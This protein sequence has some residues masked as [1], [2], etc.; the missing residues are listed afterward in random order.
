MDYLFRDF[1]LLWHH[2]DD[3]FSGGAEVGEKCRNVCE[4]LVGRHRR[5]EQQQQL[6]LHVLPDGA[7]M[8]P[9]K[10]QERHNVTIM[11]MTT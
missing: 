1:D 4:K 8:R 3:V 2:S 10:R 11:F 6:V 9:K 5:L 7:D